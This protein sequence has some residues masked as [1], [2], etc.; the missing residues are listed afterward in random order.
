MTITALPPA[1]S[2][3]D[4][5]ATFVAKADAF[6]A[7]LPNLVAE[8]TAFGAALNNLSTNGS[9]TTS[10]TIGTGSRSLIVETGKSYQLGMS[11]KIASTASPTSWMHGDVT[12]YTSGTGVL[13]VNVTTTNG[14]GTLAA[15]TVSLSAPGGATLGS[16]VYAGA[17]N[18]G[19]GADIASA[20]TINLSTATGNYVFVTGTTGI[21]GITLAQG[22]ERT[23]K[24]SGALT[25]THGASLVLPGAANISTAAGDTAIFRGEAAGVVRCISY[26]RAAVA[27]FAGQAIIQI[28][29]TATG[30]LVSGTGTIPDDDTI[31]QDTE[32]VLLISHAFTPQSASSTL[33]I[34]AQ[35][36]VNFPYA[37]AVLALFSNASANAL[38]CVCQRMT[39][40]GDNLLMRISYMVAA[41]S[42][43]ARTYSVRAGAQTSGIVYMNARTNNTVR[44]YGGVMNSYLRVTELKP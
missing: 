37:N 2:R 14:S 7:A 38:A 34:E 9:S 27:P 41:G 20:A 24:F 36:V 26:Q 16:N 43:A 29:Q 19:Q 44:G 31:P 30:E 35:V 33:L 39:T 5:P 15:W 11:V 42:T 6:I 1:P 3:S 21:T 18:E 32:G 23:V 13:V 40:G 12:S 17:Q 4:P 28:T 8:L 25:L 22:Y 10:L